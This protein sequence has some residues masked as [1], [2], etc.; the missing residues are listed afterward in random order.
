MPVN[1][2]NEFLKSV[3]NEAFFPEL[4]S[5]NFDQLFQTSETYFQKKIWLKSLHMVISLTG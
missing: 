4:F 1:H 3:H 5:P 2:A